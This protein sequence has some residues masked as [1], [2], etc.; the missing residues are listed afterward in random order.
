[1]MGGMSDEAEIRFPDDPARL[2]Q[3]APIDVLLTLRSAQGEEKPVLAG[4]CTTPHLRPNGVILVIRP[5]FAAGGPIPV[6]RGDAVRVRVRRSASEMLDGLG[7]VSWVR[8]KAFMPNGL[9]VSFV[10]V[11][12]DWDPEE[13]ALEVAAFLARLTVP[14]TS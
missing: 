2:L 1:M 3:H 13:M 11:T 12:F 14:P 5:Q 6:K 7:V 8:Q 4:R 9:A 10:G